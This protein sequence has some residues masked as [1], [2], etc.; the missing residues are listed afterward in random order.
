M[1]QSNGASPSAGNDLLPR[2]LR[3]ACWSILWERLWPAAAS[4]ATVVGL[5]LAVSWL[6][7][8]LWLPP[9]GRAIGLGIFFLLTAAAFASVFALRLPNRT[10]AL[11]RLDRNSGL[12]HR[13]ATAMSDAIA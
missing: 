12:A 7:T 4:V 11:R 10:D 8:W 1:P 5:F 2:A 13:P 3:R 9:Y 6:G